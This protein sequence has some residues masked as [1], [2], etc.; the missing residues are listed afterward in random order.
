MFTDAMSATPAR[1]NPPYDPQDPEVA[2]R[3][4]KLFEEIARN[5]TPETDAAMNKIAERF[6]GRFNGG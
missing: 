6:L 3:R 1:K 5:R 4:K 2:K